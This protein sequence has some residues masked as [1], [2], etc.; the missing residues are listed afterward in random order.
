MKEVQIA[1]T[2]DV[3]WILCHNVAE[4]VKDKATRDDAVTRLEA[5]IARIA[6][7]RATETASRKSVISTKARARLD[8]ELAVHTWAECAL[9]YRPPGLRSNLLLID[10]GRPVTKLRVKNALS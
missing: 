5:D 3:R 4:A 9:R 6:Y 2:P 8:A 7:A 1:S 10:R